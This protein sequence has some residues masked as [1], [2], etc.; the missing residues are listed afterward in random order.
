MPIDVSERKIV[1]FPAAE[2]Q[3]VRAVRKRRRVWPTYLKSNALSLCRK[4][5]I[6]RPPPRPRQSQSQSA[7]PCLLYALARQVPHE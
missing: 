2:E 6:P 1:R 3:Q 4:A 5:E 7:S